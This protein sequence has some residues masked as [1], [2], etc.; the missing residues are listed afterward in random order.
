MSKNTT[1]VP[2]QRGEAPEGFLTVRDLRVHFP[3]D[4]G[5]VK[6]VDGLNFSLVKGE[7]LGIVGESGSGKSVTSLS[8]M[9]LHRTGTK[10]G[11]PRISGEVW[12]DGEELVS[13]DPDRVRQLRGQ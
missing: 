7:T 2:G 10:R 1:I 6:S 9:G 3:T 11:A 8:I 5:L 12:L 4:D 13:A